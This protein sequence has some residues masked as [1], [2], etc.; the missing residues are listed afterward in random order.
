M[1]CDV[2]A[3]EQQFVEQLHELDHKINFLKEQD[4]REAM[5]VN[6]VHDIVDK[7]KI[8]VGTF[9]V[10]FLCEIS[11]VCYPVKLQSGEC[12]KSQ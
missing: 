11:C 6:D 8:K 4:F 2:S 5:S 10:D 1:I 3:S 7:L 12:A 9:Q